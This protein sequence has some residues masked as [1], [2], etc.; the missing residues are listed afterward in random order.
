MTTTKPDPGR[1]YVVK[2]LTDALNSAAAELEGRAK[3]L[4]HFAGLIEQEAKDD[5]SLEVF[6]SSCLPTNVVRE[7]TDAM[8]QNHNHTL[9]LIVGYANEL[10]YPRSES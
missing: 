5:P 6:R 2:M 7:F 3:G 4:R 1:T 10:T 8:R 9:T